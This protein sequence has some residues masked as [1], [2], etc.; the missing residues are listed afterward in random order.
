MGGGQGWH[1]NTL[2][3]PTFA[4]ARSAG[5]KFFHSGESPR[6]PGGRGVQTEIPKHSPQSNGPAAHKQ[7]LGGRPVRPFRCSVQSRILQHNVEFFRNTR[8]SCIQHPSLCDLPPETAMPAV[9]LS[10]SASHTATGTATPVPTLTPDL[11][12]FSVHV[13]WLPC[14]ADSSKENTGWTLTEYQSPNRNFFEESA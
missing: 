9:P 1:Q 8:T 6:F 3:Y 13:P 11:V 4:S 12:R 7:K 5:G 2:K 10:P 14:H